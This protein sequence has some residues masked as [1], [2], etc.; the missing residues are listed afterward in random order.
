MHFEGESLFVARGE[1]HEGPAVFGEFDDLRP[2]H[3]PYSGG[4]M[5]DEDTWA[6]FQ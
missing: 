3:V 2:Q 4:D 5:S 1:Y 6:D